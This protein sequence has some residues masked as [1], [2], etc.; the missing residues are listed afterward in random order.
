ME[1][2]IKEE[3]DQKPQRV[4]TL[5]ATDTEIQEFMVQHEE[6]LQSGHEHKHGAGHLFSHAVSRL[7][8]NS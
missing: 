7:R 3:Q 5:M 2:A 8:A 6:L 1:G 4:A